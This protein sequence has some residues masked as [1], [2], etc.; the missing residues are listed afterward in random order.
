M[1][2]AADMNA[3]LKSQALPLESLANPDVREAMIAADIIFGL[4][5]SRDSLELFWGAAFLRKVVNAKRD[6]GGLIVVLRYNQDL[7]DE[8][9]TLIAVVEKL[10]GAC[11]YR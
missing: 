5:T 3:K 1:S 4:D 9:T 7:D 8:L 6:R 2:E 11:C 10:K